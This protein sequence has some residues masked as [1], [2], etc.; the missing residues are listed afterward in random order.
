MGFGPMT[1]RAAGYC[2]GYPVPGFANPGFG[3]GGF[4]R[5]RGFRRRNMYFLTGM[6]GWARFGYNPYYGVGVVPA[7][8]EK[9]YLK[10]QAQF[11]EQELQQIKKRLDELEKESE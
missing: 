1:G 7:V 9:T 8:D 3:F 11:V 10:N 6:P 4:S 2:A 5:G